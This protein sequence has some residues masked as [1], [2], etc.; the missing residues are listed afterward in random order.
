MVLDKELKDL[1]RV[2]T[3]SGGN[4]LEGRLRSG[5]GIER[6]TATGGERD[7]LSSTISTAEEAMESPLSEISSIDQR[8]YNERRDSLDDTM[9]DNDNTAPQTN[10]TG[11][12][13][14]PLS[15]GPC[16]ALRSVT[17][18]SSDDDFT[19]EER[20]ALR[21]SDI[22]E[23]VDKYGSELCQQPYW[24]SKIVPEYGRIEDLVCDFLA[25]AA[26]ERDHHYVQLMHKVRDDLLGH[27]SK[28]KEKAEKE[29]SY[30]HTSR[31]N[32]ASKFGN[33]NQTSDHS[34]TEM[35]LDCPLQ[36]ER[37]KH[38]GSSL[39]DD[40]AS[41]PTDPLPVLNNVT[42]ALPG[43]S[44][45]SS[46]TVSDVTV[47]EVQEQVIHVIPLTDVFG[48]VSSAEFPEDFVAKM[49]TCDKRLADFVSSSESVNNIIKS[50]L[51]KLELQNKENTLQVAN[52]DKTVSQIK[53]IVSNLSTKVTGV[54]EVVT[55][56]KDDLKQMKVDASKLSIATKENLTRITFLKSGLDPLPGMVKSLSSAVT[57]AQESI[58]NCQMKVIPDLRDKVQINNSMI[59]AFG[60]TLKE[61]RKMI[62]ECPQVKE[63][64][65]RRGLSKAP[66]SDTVTDSGVVQGSPQGHSNE[67]P[68]VPET[69][70]SS[71]PPVLRVSPPE[72]ITRNSLTAGQGSTAADSASARHIIDVSPSTLQRSRSNSISSATSKVS[73]SRPVSVST[74][75]RSRS[76]GR[77]GHGNP[78]SQHVSNNSPAL[79]QN[80]DS[81][82]A[83]QRS[84][85]LPSE[86]VVR[87]STSHLRTSVMSSMLGT[88]IPHS[89]SSIAP[90]DPSVTT[91]SGSAP[92]LT[93]SSQL[94]F[95][96]LE[97]HITGLVSTISSKTKV[98][99]D[100][101]S[102]ELLIKEAKIHD[103]P[104]LDRY[105][106]DLFTNLQE[107]YIKSPLCDQIVVQ[108]ASLALEQAREWINQVETAFVEHEVYSVDSGE[109]L[110]IEL[111]V[112][113]GAGPQTV[114]EF[115]D[116]FE[117][118]HR[119][120]ATSKEKAKQLFGS[121]LTEE[122][123][124]LTS[125]ISEN[126]IGLK[127]WL[128]KQFGNSIAAPEC[129]LQPLEKAVR[130]ADKDAQA[131]AKYFLSIRTAL[132]KMEKLADRKE[133]DVQMLQSHLYSH[134]FMKRLIDM[135][136]PLDQS[137]FSR[138]LMTKGFD[139]MMVHGEYA[140]K[141]FS[142]FCY[143]E[144][145][146]MERMSKAEARDDSN[147]GIERTK[148]PDKNRLGAMASESTRRS[149][150]GPPRD[151]YVPISMTQ[152]EIEEDDKP[153]ENN[154]F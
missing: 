121:Y 154:F 150:S 64:R 72:G 9:I 132:E 82:P 19:N 104:A 23:E 83:S 79:A 56:L 126:Y 33:V 57:K 88:S 16:H 80:D 71:E 1:Q 42:N 14:T 131:R 28:W 10:M 133:A 32:S 27:R 75:S 145:H 66:P 50:S 151:G 26:Q 144:G 46:S 44:S 107:K 90:T 113:T 153:Y 139:S 129:I 22:C 147:K 124:T 149:G 18:I 87:G 98:R 97:G 85:A 127:E 111:Q 41:Q 20:I 62:K 94:E 109:N 152:D 49:Q 2:N 40:T 8:D 38:T 115:L 128:V 116:D 78:V 54:E 148:E 95:K 123:K 70:G 29:L 36:S 143:N 39:P 34:S 140:F 73:S 3:Q 15:T 102:S 67:A 114:F 45:A 58:T 81:I 74:R 142:K 76:G 146:A 55:E 93:S 17:S 96:L 31:L 4:E 118:K 12:L 47:E 61:Q 112:F 99:I 53:I 25:V 69:L 122:I 110:A 52:L 137:E 65:I 11:Y 63:Y 43:P 68:N 136:P 108:K 84:T 105:Y 134:P 103:V 138:V 60:I 89:T 21:Y 35:S 100:S 135:I 119:S 24:Q 120:V 86:S 59:D 117:R 101:T 7:R 48:N 5:T 77:I 37:S 141:E 30:T 51:A 13:T 6:N 130:P 92:Q 91:I 125:S 106:K